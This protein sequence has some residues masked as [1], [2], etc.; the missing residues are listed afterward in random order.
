MSYVRQFRAIFPYYANDWI[1]RQKA[2]ATFFGELGAH[3]PAENGSTI[4]ADHGC[5]TGENLALLCR[6]LKPLTDL[7]TLRV[8]A[9]DQNPDLASETSERLQRLGIGAS[10][11]TG[12]GLSTPSNAL[13]S[14]LK[15]SRH[16]HV[17][18]SMLEHVVYPVVNDYDRLVQSLNSILSLI[19]PNGLLVSILTHNSDADDVR[20]N[21]S[22]LRDIST[23]QPTQR[24]LELAGRQGWKIFEIPIRAQLIDPGISDSEWDEIASG[25]VKP[26][27][28]PYSNVAQALLMLEFSV[29][30][31]EV[32]SG[33]GILESSTYKFREK[34]KRGFSVDANIQIIP[35]KGSSAGFIEAV[36]RA[37]SVAA[38]KQAPGGGNHVR[39]N[40]VNEVAA[41]RLG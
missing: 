11:T 20:Q 25:R 5:G 34:I 35:S 17:S 32:L 27:D 4:L 2:Y 18:I 21:K 22:D 39:L 33:R 10:V 30:P 37:A 9:V 41:Y 36:E 6:T 1:N 40:S 13:R 15:L 29:A 26:G 3:F 14:V 19:H 16:E 31:H 8:C 12:N 23:D 28:D 24:M 38:Q 7:N